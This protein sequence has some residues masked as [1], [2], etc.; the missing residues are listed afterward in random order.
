MW[1]AW[2]APLFTDTAPLGVIV[3][4]APLVAVIVQLPSSANA[5]SLKLVTPVSS[6][7][8]AVRVPTVGYVQVD[9][10]YLPPIRAAVLAPPTT[11]AGSKCRV[12]LASVNDDAGAVDTVQ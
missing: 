8:V 5:K 11:S 2:S 9:G 7:L 10:S 6:V 4:W 3:P 1:N 12:T